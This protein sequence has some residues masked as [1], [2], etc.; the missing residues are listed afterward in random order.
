[1]TAVDFAVAA[2]TMKLPLTEMGKPGGG[3]DI[4]EGQELVLHVLFLVWDRLVLDVQAKMFLK[5]REIC[6]SGD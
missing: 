1:M 4:R 3:A 2:G 6:G 5:S